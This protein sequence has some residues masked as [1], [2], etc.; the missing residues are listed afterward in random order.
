MIIILYLAACVYSHGVNEPLNYFCA[1]YY[2]V[3]CALNMA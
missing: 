2:A 3:Y 1:L